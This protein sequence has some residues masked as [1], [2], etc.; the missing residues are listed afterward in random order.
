MHGKF[1]R[2]ALFISGFQQTGA[3]QFVNLQSTTNHSM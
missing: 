1:M 3:Q 2:Q